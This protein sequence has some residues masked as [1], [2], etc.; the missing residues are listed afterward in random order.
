MLPV[1]KKIS[2]TNKI[3]FTF[4]ML[5]EYSWSTTRRNSNV[6]ICEICKLNIANLERQNNNYIEGQQV[7]I[8]IKSR[9]LTRLRFIYRNH[10]F[11]DA[12]SSLFVSLH[13]AEDIMLKSCITLNIHCI[14]SMISFYLVYDNDL[15]T[16]RRRHSKEIYKQWCKNSRKCHQ[17]DRRI[18]NTQN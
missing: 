7:F 16:K 2:R 11:Y 1:T 12:L 8:Y 5:N 13:I 15:N 10:Y 17:S 18:D 14:K 6:K 9:I 3:I 4:V